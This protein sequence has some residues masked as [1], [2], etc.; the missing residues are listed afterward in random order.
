MGAVAGRAA[1]SGTD[2]LVMQL[3]A[4]FLNRP[5]QAIGPFHFA[6]AARGFVVLLGIEV[7]A[8]AA[9]FLGQVAGGVGLREQVLQGAVGSSS[10]TR[11]CWR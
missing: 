3:Q 2:F 11:R 7:N 10:I 6:P 9:A 1:P 8:V 4:L 5:A